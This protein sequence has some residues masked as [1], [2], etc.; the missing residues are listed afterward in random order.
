M[1]HRVVPKEDP[2]LHVED[3]KY[4]GETGDV[5]AHF[6]KPKGE[7]KL[8]G[9]VVICEIWGLVDH[10][11]EVARR[12]ALEGFLAIAPDALS[13]LGGTPE[14]LD[15]DLAGDEAGRPVTARNEAGG[16]DALNKGFE[17]QHRGTPTLSFLVSL[18]LEKAGRHEPVAGIVSDD[19]D[20]F[21]AWAR[22]LFGGG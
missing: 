3:I 11:K 14:G 4:R 2:R 5:S 8:P 17:H 1:G 9:V 20:A 10:I 13:P 18:A 19:G 6:A 12:V 7:A 15:D 21:A 16:R 22:R